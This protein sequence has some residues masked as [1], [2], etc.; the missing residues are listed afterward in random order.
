VP[1]PSPAT[2]TVVGGSVATGAPALSSE[3]VETLE[4]LAALRDRGAMS[5]DEYQAEKTL[6]MHN[7]K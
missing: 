7:G 1:P 6:V 3:R 5:N 2:E 4:R